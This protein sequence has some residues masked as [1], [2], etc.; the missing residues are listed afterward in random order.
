MGNI[1][2]YIRKKIIWSGLNCNLSYTA[3][4]YQYGKMVFDLSDPDTY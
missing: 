3:N 4:I 1:L 2:P